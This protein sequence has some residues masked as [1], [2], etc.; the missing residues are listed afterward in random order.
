MLLQVGL[1]VQLEILDLPRLQVGRSERLWC[2][3]KIFVLLAYHQNNLF[4]AC[5]NAN[6]YEQHQDA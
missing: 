1:Y 4:G 3:K 5:R 6:E 2:R